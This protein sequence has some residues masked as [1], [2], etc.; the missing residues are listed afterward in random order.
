M[1]KLAVVLAPVVLVITAIPAFSQR[2]F[3]DAPTVMTMDEG[4]VPPS[5]YD[6]PQSSTFGMFDTGDE[7]TYIV[8][9][10][11]PGTPYGFVVE[12]NTGF[13]TAAMS[14]GPMGGSGPGCNG[15]ITLARPAVA[16]NTRVSFYT[17]QAVSSWPSDPLN[18]YG[19]NN[20]PKQGTDSDGG[21]FYYFPY[22]NLGSYCGYSGTIN[23]TFRSV[24]R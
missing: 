19:P 20:M 1:K 21:T 12:D 17:S 8:E 15:S 24:T 5:T 9:A 16:G 22:T 13:V 2:Q 10:Y 7:T 11:T 14:C 23:M 18:A 4:C 3:T 6:A